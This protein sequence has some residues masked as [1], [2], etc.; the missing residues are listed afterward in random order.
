MLVTKGLAY[1]ESAL[2]K[3]R[4]GP[5]IDR[6]VDLLIPP[7]EIESVLPSLGH[8]SKRAELLRYLADLEDPLPPLAEVVL[9]HVGY[10]TKSPVLALAEKGWVKILPKQTKLDVPPGLRVGGS[11]FC[12]NRPSSTFRPVYG[13]V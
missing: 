3:P 9:A 6:M 7:D 13:S 12:P 11:R 2:A 1:K 10:A 8:Q 4:V 5:K